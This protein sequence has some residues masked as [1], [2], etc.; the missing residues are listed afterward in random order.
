VIRA[1]VSSWWLAAAVAAPPA[2]YEVPRATADRKAL[3]DSRAEAWKGAPAITWGP[4]SYETT[5]RAFWSGEGLHVLFE[6]RDPDPWHTFSRHDERLY[7]EEVVEIFLD[8]DR[9]GTHYAEVQWNPVNAICDYHVIAPLPAYKGNRSWTFEGIESRVEIR[10]EGERTT[11]WVTAAFL[12]WTGL[13]ALPSVANIPLP[14]RPGDRWR[15]NVFRIERPHGPKDPERDVVLAAWSP[16]PIPKF[17]VPSAFR[18]LV[19]TEPA[20]EDPLVLGTR[21]HQLA[22]Y[23]IDEEPATSDRALADVGDPVLEFILAAPTTWD[24]RLVI[25]GLPPGITAVAR[26]KGAEW[27]LGIVTEAGA[28]TVEIPLA[29]LGHEHFTA[30]IYA[31][32]ADADRFPQHV[33]VEKRRVDRATRLLARLAP[34]GGYAVRLVPVAY[35]F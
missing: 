30:E 29:F 19:F 18:D 23:V 20:K 13:A 28:G 35:S 14:P 10:K 22:T 2:A 12:P 24:E 31:D 8:P 27:F 9:S 15:F 25:G 11:G 33:A 5:F 1:I 26:R 6:A 17:H 7:D 3:L 21:A 16:A 34:G 4:A 32:A